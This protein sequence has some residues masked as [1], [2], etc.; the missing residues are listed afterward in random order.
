[1]KN[2]FI[3]DSQ[4]IKDH[5]REGEARLEMGKQLNIPFSCYYPLN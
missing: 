1:M 3:S 5:I 4:S 2:K